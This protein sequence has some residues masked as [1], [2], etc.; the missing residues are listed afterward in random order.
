MSSC[1]K[2]AAI[3][4]LRNFPSTARKKTVYQPT[5]SHFAFFAVS[6]R[7]GASHGCD[8][9]WIRAAA[10]AARPCCCCSTRL[11]NPPA[12][13]SALLPRT[14]LLCCSSG[15][16]VCAP[17]LGNQAARGKVWSKSRGRSSFPVE[18]VAE[19]PL[20]LC[21]KKSAAAPHSAGG[22]ASGAAGER[23][24]GICVRVTGLLLLCTV[25]H[26]FVRET[27]RC[28]RASHSAWERLASA[29][30]TMAS[31]GH[32][33]LGGFRIFSMNSCVNIGISS[34]Y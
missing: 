4:L 5:W 7:G 13:R 23:A 22:G 18:Q 31:P 25:L 20:L 32:I 29:F 10:A 33:Y 34:K 26:F 8:T 12:Q 14:I 3:L 2:I 16:G 28:A 6:D 19:L 17:R 9:G 30:N 15:S 27:A 24:A 11:C 21:C 1:D